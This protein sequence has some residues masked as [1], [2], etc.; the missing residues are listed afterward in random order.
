L[1]RL[2]DGQVTR[3]AIHLIETGRARPSDS[4]L[5]LIS[6]GT[7]R[8]V[9]YFLAV[10][11]VAG[12]LPAAAGRGA[13]SEVRHLRELAARRAYVEL[14][15]AAQELLQDVPGQPAE[16]EVLFHLGLAHANLGATREGIDLLRRAREL[17][18]SNDIEGILRIECLDWLGVA[19]HHAEDPAAMPA[20]EEALRRCHNQTPPAADLEARILGH[21]G[22][23]HA[24]RHEWQ[25]AS[26]AYS[27][28]IEVAGNLSQMD[29]LAR[30]YNDLAGAAE[31]LGDIVGAL[32]H[33]RK[34][35]AI[36]EVIGDEL[37]LARIENNVGSLLVKNARPRDG[38][39]YLNRALE[40]CERLGIAYGRAK[41]LLSLAEAH[42]ADGQPE[43]AATRSQEAAL[44]TRESGERLTEAQALQLL[45]MALDQTG[46]HQ[47]ADA[48][49]GRALA[50]LEDGKAPERLIELHAR[51]ARLWEGR[52]EHP[53]AAAQWKAALSLARP[54]L[55]VQLIPGGAREEQRETA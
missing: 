17:M 49:M 30:M 13:S 16:A 33:A 39:D 28:A 34:G 47:E 4:T 12:P 52:R 21:L 6:E 53:Q 3:G 46:R 35:L 19:L 22:A 10:Q 14:A 25:S 1:A 27:Q 26:E 42:L 48:S 11:P 8:P 20:L 15:R 23:V 29:L 51:W 32:V 37:S 45:A 41:V 31:G 2:A 5:R 36:T 24:S 40:R 50:I 54:G 43:D 9:A 44:L 18:E 38:L 7:G 55:Q